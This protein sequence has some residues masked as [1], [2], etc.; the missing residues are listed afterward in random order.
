VPLIGPDGPLSPEDQVTFDAIERILDGEGIPLS[1]GGTG[2]PLP[3][4]V[5]LDAGEQA[6]ARAAVEAYNVAIAATGALHDLA[7]VDIHRIVS[8]I[9]ENGLVVGGDTLTTEYLVGGLFSLDGVHPTCKG[10]GVVANA[11]I[12]AI[13]ERYGLALPPVSIAGL[14]GVT[15][16]AAG[17][18][19]PAGARS[20]LPRLTG[21]LP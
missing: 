15:L 6:V 2:Q 19:V 3:G 9:D 20:G 7:V 16:T 8:E 14:P 17:D 5:V 21:R 18:R 4:D 12:D 11:L 10:Q 1:M 13:E